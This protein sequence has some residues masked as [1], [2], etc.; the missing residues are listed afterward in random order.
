LLETTFVHYYK[1]KAKE[2]SFEEE[3][4]PENCPWDLACGLVKVFADSY[5]VKLVR[6]EIVKGKRRA[7]ECSLRLV[8]YP[9]FLYSLP[10]SCFQ[11]LY[12][13]RLL[14]Q[15][16]GKGRKLKLDHGEVVG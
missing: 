12:D 15:R 4:I 6:K 7:T 8:Q 10:P 3:K 14:E 5:L 13:D 2:E 1:V 16:N 9:S 11:L